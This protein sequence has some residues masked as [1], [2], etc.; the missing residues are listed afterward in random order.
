[1]QLHTWN[2]HR[3]AN[4][5]VEFVVCVFVGLVF[6]NVCTF[7]SFVYAVSLYRFLSYNLNSTPKPSS[8]PCRHEIEAGLGWNI[9]V[10]IARHVLGSHRDEC[11]ENVQMGEL[12][13]NG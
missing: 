4:H 6:T 3:K 8:R 5:D 9:P 10:I 13:S 1:M 12:R 7:V 11:A 2:N